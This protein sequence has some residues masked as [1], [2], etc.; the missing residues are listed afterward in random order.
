MFVLATL[1]LDIKLYVLLFHLC[2]I[3]DVSIGKNFLFGWLPEA[4]KWCAS[5]GPS[6]DGQVVFTYPVL[7]I[8]G[9][10]RYASTISPIFSILDP[11]CTHFSSSKA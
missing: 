3:C 1:R 4:I 8:T 5:K 6:K 2:A 9:T 11:N 7:F 10:H